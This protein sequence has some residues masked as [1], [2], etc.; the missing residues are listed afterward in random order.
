MN[1]FAY[2]FTKGG[3]AIAAN[4]FNQIASQYL[5]YNVC[6]CEVKKGV[7]FHFCKRLVSF[8]LVKMQ[9]D[10]NPIKHSLNL[11]SDRRMVKK[12]SSICQTPTHI[13]WINNDTI[14]IFDFDKIPSGA[15]VSLHDEW[16][17]CG[18][19]HVAILQGKTYEPEF[20]TGYKFFKPSF[21]GVNW[22]YIIWRI[23]LKKLSQ[24]KDLL[25][26][27]PSSWM[28]DRAKKSV[29]LQELDIK[30]LPNPINTDI[31]KRSDK[32]EIERFRM[33]QGIDEND[34]VIAFGSF[35]GNANFYKGQH[36]LNE[37]LTLFEKNHTN[38]FSNNIKFV[39]F[40]AKIPKRNNNVLELGFFSNE[41]D[42]SLFYSSIDCL[43]ITSMVESFGQVAAEAV[44]CE[45]PVV[46]F[47]TSGLR[48][49]IIDGET[50][51]TAPCYNVKALANQIQ[52]IVEMDEKERK[53]IGKKGRKH[54]INN[55]SFPKVAEKYA[56]VLKQ[57]QQ[58]VNA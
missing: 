16:L 21:V 11:F 28:L 40:G 42:L 24:R 5:D 12:M 23:K 20:V 14:S 2:S 39:S 13:H 33:R 19:E 30:L 27:V 49:I 45:A 17:Y 32:T 31:F 8:L 15:I 1:V 34:F 26:T 4:K 47:A 10:D 44:S 55:F 51:L 46:C 43:I 3:A 54:I 38:K 22:N 9:Y 29:I 48:D 36:L 37:A 35:S 25:F 52:K 6:V 58:K 50:G 7:S 18:A 57:A 56:A 53:S 41:T